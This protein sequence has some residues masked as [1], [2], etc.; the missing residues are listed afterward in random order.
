MFHRSA[1]ALAFLLLFSSLAVVPVG[2]SATGHNG[3]EG[4]TQCLNPASHISTA[5][6]ADDANYRVKFTPRLNGVVVAN[7]TRLDIWSRSTVRLSL[8][9]GY[10]VESAT[11]FDVDNS[12][13]RTGL[14]F[15]GETDD[16]SFVYQARN[17][18]HAKSGELERS[19]KPYHDSST[20]YATSI[21]PSHGGGPFLVEFPNGGHIGSTLMRVG[22][23]DRVE[24]ISHGCHTIEIVVPEGADNEAVD[25]S[26]EQLTTVQRSFKGGGYNAKATLFVHPDHNNGFGTATGEDVVYG[27]QWDQKADGLSTPVHEYIHTRQHMDVSKDMWWYIEASASYHTARSLYDSDHLTAAEYDYTLA[28]FTRTNS[29]GDLTNWRT[30][31]TEQFPYDYGGVYLSVLDADLREATD[32]K[33]TM[34]DVFRDLNQ[35]D[36]VDTQAF[37]RSLQRHGLN[38]TQA[39]VEANLSNPNELTPAYQQSEPIVNDLIREPYTNSNILSCFSTIIFYYN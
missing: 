24:T 39:D 15:N 21:I 38:R 4:P 20:K 11:G 19:I 27:D 29:S 30:W 9:A 16:P 12:S 22:P 26:I 35:R 18:E 3:T 17:V 14:D 31:P 23:V 37:A 8:P 6:T 10:T 13:N 5:D 32:G 34:K 1:L 25:R 28:Q 2:V 33:S 36:E 7:Y